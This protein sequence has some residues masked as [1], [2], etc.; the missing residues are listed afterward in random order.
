MTDATTR[1]LSTADALL[2]LLVAFLWG[3][4]FV[5]IAVGLRGLPPLL[6][7][8]LRFFFCAV[9]GIFIV[10][11]P[12]IR[13][14]DLL[15]VG[16]MLGTLVFAFLFA[17]IAAGMPAGLA[18]LIMQSQIFFTI[19]FGVVLLKERPRPMNWLAIA[20]G[21]AGIVTISL[22]R[23]GAGNIL[24]FLLLL[25]GA[26]SWGIANIILKHLPKTGMLPLMIWMSIVPP[27]PLLA[28]SLLLEGTDRITAAFLDPSPIVIGAVLYTGLLST[29]LAY[30]IWGHM[31]QKYETALVAPFA[32]LV[33]V[34]GL[35]SAA[36]VLGEM[37]SSAELAASALVLAGL[38]LNVWGEQGL[39]LLRRP[40]TLPSGLMR[41]RGADAVED[42]KRLRGLSSDAAS[43][44]E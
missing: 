28:A 5:V 44:E 43:H 27:L 42:E 6:M 32:M 10:P 9:P 41:L 8:S 24:A 11:R 1:R 15:A 2:L 16:I 38:A 23:S 7:A 34:F 21:A 12:A 4:N 33:P 35:L 3:F 36:L 18:S 19:L 17:G 40:R 26:L 20:V 39:A 22:E 30:G 31:L 29:I 25:A 37:P 14:R 13:W